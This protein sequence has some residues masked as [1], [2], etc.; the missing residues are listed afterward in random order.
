MRRAIC[1]FLLVVPGVA[2]ADGT[3]PAGWRFPTEA[4]YKDAWVEYRD[5]FP[6]PFH[7][8]ADFDGDGV[9]DHAWILI[10]REGNGFGLFVFFGSRKGNPHVV[11]VFA[12][13]E[14]CAQ[15][16]AL[17]L[18]S[19]GRHLTVCGRGGGGGECSPAQPK[20]VTLKYSGFE[21]IT[22]GTASGLYY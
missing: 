8:S 5:R 16:Y 1:L 6:V 13:D 22:L 3:P 18:V 2:I 10:R 21:F 11:E 12:Y 20:S 7:V 19:P 14:C 17:A 4:D 9:V 15:S